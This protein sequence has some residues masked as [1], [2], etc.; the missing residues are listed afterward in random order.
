MFNLQDPNISYLIITP[1]KDYNH[2]TDN[3]HICERVCSILYSKDYTLIPMQSF[4]EGKYSKSFFAVSSSDNDT[5]RMDSIFL[6]DQF[7]QKSVVVKY[8]H[9]TDPTKISFDGSER[10]MS[11][12][13]YE[14][15]SRDRIYLHN[16]I[17]FC[18][19]EQK[20]YFFPKKKEELKNGM[21]VEYF[22][23]NRWCSKKVGNIDT[24][25]EKMY[26]LLMKYE[27]LRIESV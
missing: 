7:E 9:E 14:S 25:Y 4:M 1:E 16:G 26:K 17:S 20:R 23:N 2:P 10:T 15:E 19:H 6:M 5:L 3:H 24:E 21:V 11:L 12:L 27:K 18:F 22:N 8:R 13:V